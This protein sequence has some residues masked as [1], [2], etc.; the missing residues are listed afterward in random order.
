MNKSEKG[1]LQGIAF[2]LFS[3]SCFT[4]T[5]YLPDNGM[6]A[7]VGIIFSIVGIV[8]VLFSFFQEK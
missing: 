7:M 4:A 6:S 5:P 3:I 1:I 8:I 2:I